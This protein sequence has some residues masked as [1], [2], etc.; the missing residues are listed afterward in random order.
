MTGETTQVRWD[1]TTYLELTKR[2]LEV[3]KLAADGLTNKEIGARM[4]ISVET[5]KSH[6]RK[7]LAK[8]D[9]RNR[10]HLVVTVVRKGII[11]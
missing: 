9:C 6:V 7:A 8:T 2:E 1:A 5:V 4:F 11:E 3:L 10:T